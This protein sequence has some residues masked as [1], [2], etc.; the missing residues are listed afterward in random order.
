MSVYTDPS[1]GEDADR[2][3]GVTFLHKPFTPGTLLRRVRD[4]LDGAHR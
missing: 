4:V 3:H 1:M 2:A